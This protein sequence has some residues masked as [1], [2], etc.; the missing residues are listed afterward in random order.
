M[1]KTLSAALPHLGDG[2]WEKCGGGEC[3]GGGWCGGVGG[4]IG[5]GGGGGVEED[6]E[7]M[8]RVLGK[9]K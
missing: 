2:I 1:L 7:G 8:R 4:G 3:G 5:G 9:W 6:R